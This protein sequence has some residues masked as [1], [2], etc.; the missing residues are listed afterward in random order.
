MP[1]MTTTSLRARPEITS[2]QVPPSMP[3]LTSV[4]FTFSR[5]E[6]RRAMIYIASRSPAALA[7]AA[8]GVA[9]VAAGLGA[10]K[11]VLTVG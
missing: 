1:A 6:S 10:G 11:A 4:R 8:L 2:S 9:L 3:V 7:M 5:A